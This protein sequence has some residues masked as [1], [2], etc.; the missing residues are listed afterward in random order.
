MFF[1]AA[2]LFLRTPVCL[3]SSISFSKFLGI[4]DF[5][6]PSLAEINYAFRRKIH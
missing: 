5:V 2:H 3:N 1:P 6:I 4:I